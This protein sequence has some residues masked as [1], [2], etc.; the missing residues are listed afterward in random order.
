MIKSCLFPPGDYV[1]RDTS[2]TWWF[3][4]W[5]SALRQMT[6]GRETPSLSSFCLVQECAPVHLAL[7]ILQTTLSLRRRCLTSQAG[8][9]RGR[10]TDPIAQLLRCV[11]GNCL[12]PYTAP[13]KGLDTLCHWIEWESVPKVLIFIVFFS[14]LHLIWSV[15]VPIL[16]KDGLV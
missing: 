1:S 7:F 3:L 15:S 16:L 12:V 5:A 2:S 4:G 11:C 9:P 14:Q 10:R 6:G 13:V 8:W